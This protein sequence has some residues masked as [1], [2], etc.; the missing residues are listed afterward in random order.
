MFIQNATNSATIRS[1]HAIITRQMADVLLENNVDLTD[2]DACRLE[3]RR[4]NFGKPAIDALQ[5][6]ACGLA[7]QDFV[8][9]W[10]P[11]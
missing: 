1:L 4:A 8:L 9:N 3:L 5:E 10:Q 7:A 11:Q 2:L 6:A